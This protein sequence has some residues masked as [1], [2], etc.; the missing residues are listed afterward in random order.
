MHTH[1][2]R[3]SE[4]RKEGRGEGGKEERKKGGRAEEG[5][6]DMLTHTPFQSFKRDDG[7]TSQ[8]RLL[9]FFWPSIARRELVLLLLNT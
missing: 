5:Q 7:P 4:E 3:E 1:T 8:A 6:A 9:F 2:E